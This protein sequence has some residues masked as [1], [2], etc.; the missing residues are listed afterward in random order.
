MRTETPRRDAGVPDHE[1]RLGSRTLSTG[2]M[3]AIA[4]AY[5]RC[6]G[7]S[8][9]NDVTDID[10]VGI[11]VYTSVRPNAAA[12]LNTMTSGKGLT[13]DAAWVSAAMEAVERRFCEPRPC[14]RVGSY[15]QLAEQELVL[16]P[17][18]LNL[19]RGHRWSPSSELSW[20]RMTEL[21]SGA[22]VLVPAAAL[23]TPYEDGLS[24]FTSNTIGLASGAS[25]EEA[26]LHGLYEVL[27]HDATA[28]GEVGHVGHA[29]A[30]DSL[31]GP[32]ADL[33]DRFERADVSAQLYH[34][35]GR[36]GLP[37][38]YA[39]IRDELVPDPLLINGGAGCDADPQT[40][41]L[42]ALCEAAQSRLIVIAGS[43]ED[44][45]QESYR[46]QLSYRAAKERLELW[47]GNWP[48]VD[49]GDIPGL[50]AGTV[51]DQLR[52]TLGRM[53]AAGLP[54]VLARIMTA[55]QDPL[56]VVRVVVPG[57]E[58]T[59]LDKRRCGTAM[60]ALLNGEAAA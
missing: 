19:R 1:G 46:R 35:P 37:T 59:H 20:C 21:S 36:T 52:E 48:S 8:R 30:R 38:F 32:V 44:L 50:P 43:R 5:L 15:Q 22:E 34:F 47:S 12:G 40:A 45:D 25:T 58:Y 41:A 7:V 9:V 23:F 53:R 56:S 39:T 11:P 31:P 55:P 24:M 17:R 10:R 49:F 6:A 27:E 3:R 28:F 42:R 14:D 51:A 54:L 33:V 26:L 29:V 13:P 16:D 18:K 60:S 2:Q 57:I 4:D